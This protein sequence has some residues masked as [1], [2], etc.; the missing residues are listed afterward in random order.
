MLSTRETT[1]VSHKRFDSDELVS[2]ALRAGELRPI[3]MGVCEGVAFGRLDI[4]EGSIAYDA[5]KTV[6]DPLGEDISHD[7]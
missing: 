7:Q 6:S 1:R 5:E 2:N 4:D 3:Q